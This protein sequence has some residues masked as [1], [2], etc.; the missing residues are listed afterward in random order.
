MENL[1]PA[2][3]LLLSRIARKGDA[4]ARATVASGF[5]SVDDFTVTVKG[6][7]LEVGEDEPYTPT[8]SVPLLQTLTIALHRAG[9]QRDAIAQMVLDAAS[10][11]IGNGGKVGDELESTITYVQ[12]EVKDLRKKLSEGLPTKT[13]KGKVKVTGRIE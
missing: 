3:S 1:T 4:T 5:Y 6:G 7:I 2:Q 12:D 8:V 11:A 9:F 10:T 13:R